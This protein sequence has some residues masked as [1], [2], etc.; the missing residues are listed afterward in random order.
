MKKFAHWSI[1]YKL[2]SLLLLLGVMTFAVTGTIAYIKYLNA[3]KRDVMN[4][5]TGLN[6]AKQ[7]QIE[8]Y[9]QTIHNHAATLSDDRMFI[10]A[11]REFSAAYQK[12]NATAIPAE[13]MEAVREDYKDHF[14][15]DMQKLGMARGRYEDYLPFTPAAIQLQDLYIIKNPNPQGHRDELANA[16]DGSDYSRVHEKYHRSFQNII[17]KFGY[18]DLYLIDYDTGR[19]V[20]DVAKD[21]DFG[22]SLKEGPYRDSN[23]A[24]V[25]RQCAATNN[26]DDVFFSD[27]EPY[28]ASKGEPT[29]YVASPIWDGQ[30]R[31]GILAL[32]LSTVA[33]DDVMTDKHGWERDGL[34]QT[35]ESVIIG[36]D[37]LLRTN[38]RQYLENPDVFLARL[39][40][41]G[42]PEEKL[43]RIRIYKTTIL[44]IQ[45]K[46]P[47]VIAALGGKEGTT[48]ERN[49]RG[50]GTASLVSYMP[51]HIEGLHW[52]IASRM[53]L[54]EALK[55]VSEMQRLFSWWGTGLLLLTVI[56]AWYM[57][58]QILRPVNALVAAA[59]KV[60]A[61]DLTAKVEWKYKDELG[62]LSDTFNSMT[63]SIREKTELIEQKNRE[64][65]RL[66]LNILPP[67]IATRLKGGEHEIADS[68]A[69]VTV[70]FGDLV[71]FTAMSSQTSPAEIVEMLNGLFSL[72]DETA[73]ELGIEKIKTIGD[74]Y[75]AVCGLPRLCSDHADRMAR[76]ALRMLEATEQY[77]KEVGLN[78]RLRIGINSGP[79]VAGVI[80][81]TKFIYDLWGDTV[82]LAS[83]MEST[84]VPGEI[85]VTRSVY[86]RLKDSFEFESRGVV[87]VKGKGEIEAWLLHGQLRAAE[88]LQ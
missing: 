10:D 69:D 5:L 26:P 22:T 56:A 42:V 17:K 86:E 12:L 19:I 21:R 62:I 80:G 43:D 77:G 40:A 88:V 57:T 49:V 31:L 32:Q 4:Q 35:G 54:A 16:G 14:Y 73:H 2:L 29:Q 87:Q 66:L 59:Q 82:N 60:A 76:M 36:D 79:V 44:Q 78:L 65:E 20:Y 61:G 81:A 15:P 68:F 39:K 72:F 83:R 34:G 45:A 8:D 64:N 41:N 18:Y 30:D 13:A 37:Y 6:R 38:A 9:Y 28:E 3:L 71:G 53:F 48:I 25:I 67:E 55:P 33:I 58:R 46:F 27:F 51:L 47:S 24:R 1:R 85:Q 75:M 52:A 63:K 70:L 23:L 7:F 74:C 84:G 11:M 50:Q